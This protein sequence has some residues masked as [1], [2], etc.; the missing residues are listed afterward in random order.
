MN[1]QPSADIL[2]ILGATNQV[3]FLAPNSWTDSGEGPCDTHQIKPLA[4]N[5]II[6]LAWT[7]SAFMT[8]TCS[9]LLHDVFSLDCLPPADNTT[10]THSCRL[11]LKNL[12]WLIP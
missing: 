2:P 9:S 1:T 6:Y 8:R 12:S 7:F 3:F 4:V 5:F 11:F 10:D